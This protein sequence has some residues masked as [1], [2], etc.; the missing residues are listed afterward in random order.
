MVNETYFSLQPNSFLQAEKVTAT[1]DRSRQEQK[2]E[3]CSLTSDVTTPLWLLREN[4]RA[5]QALTPW[6]A[7]T[8]IDLAI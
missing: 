6:P 3:T 4:S 1:P 2:P 5:S 8:S 7:L